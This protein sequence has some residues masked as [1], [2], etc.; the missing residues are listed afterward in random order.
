MKTKI[1]VI[2]DLH[3][4][5]SPIHGLPDR[6]GEQAN[7]LLQKAILEL[8]NHIK[9]DITVILGDMIDRSDELESEKCLEILNNSID[10]LNSKVIVL[11]GN[12]D[13]EQEIFSKI[14]GS[15]P[16]FIDINDLRFIPFIDKDEPGC[17]A[18]R[19]SL[20]IERMHNLSAGFSGQMVFLQHV[21]LFPPDLAQGYYNYTNLDELLTAIRALPNP[22]LTIAG[23]EHA[24]ME[25][26]TS[27]KDRFIAAPALCESPFQFLMIEIDGDDIKCE[28]QQL[29]N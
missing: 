23:H 20:D 25:M 24:G 12:H 6:K 14:M 1:A 8:N 2:T 13:P 26:V 17:N 9:P 29:K 21:P 3:Y 5:Q 4:S 10:K 18:S 28:Y 16:D 15:T 11:R 22:T 27:G 7:E 19:S